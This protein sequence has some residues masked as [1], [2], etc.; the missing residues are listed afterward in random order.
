M[1]NC[2]RYEAK[3]EPDAGLADRPASAGGEADA[4]GSFRDEL[5]AVSGYYRGEDRG[6]AA[7]PVAWRYRRRRAGDPQRANPGRARRDGSLASGVARGDGKA[8]GPAGRQARAPMRPL[9][10]RQPS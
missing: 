6:R 9:A 7:Q 3:D 4:S 8:P 5:A 1:A 2:D 10:G